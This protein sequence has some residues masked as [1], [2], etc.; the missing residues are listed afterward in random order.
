MGKIL[1]DNS[2]LKSLFGKKNYERKKGKI[3]VYKNNDIY[4][5]GYHKW[6]RD[7]DAVLKRGQKICN[8]GKTSFLNKISILRSKIEH[9][10][11]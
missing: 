4:S 10:I 6:L 11:F 7:D 9:Q 1:L 8:R 3:Y 2:E 5:H